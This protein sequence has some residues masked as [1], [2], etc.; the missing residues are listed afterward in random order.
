M[1]GIFG[2]IHWR[3]MAQ[4]KLVRHM[5]QRVPHRGPDGYS[6]HAEPVCVIGSG[7]LAII[8]LA[9]QPGVVYNEDG[10]VCIVFNGEIYNYRALRDELERAG[11]EFITRTDTEVI[12]HGYEEWGERVLDRL[13]GMF[14]F[15]IWDARA[16]ALFLAR[17]RLGEKP[18]Y[19]IRR[20]NGEFLFASETK[21][22]FEHP[23]IR[24]AVNM[25]ALPAYLTL[26]YVPPPMT[27]FA[28]I[29]KLAPGEYARLTPQGLT[30]ARY[31]TPQMNTETSISYEEAVRDVRKAVIDAVETRL[32]SDVPVGAFLS[33][34]VDST[35]VVAIMQRAMGQRLHTF[36]VGFD[37]PLGSVGDVKFNVDDQYAKKASDHIGTIHHRI[38]IQDAFV[39][40]LLPHLIYQMDEP[41]AQHSIIQTSYVAALARH[42][43]IPVLLSGDAGDELF[44]GYNHYQN[45]QML[46]RFLVLPALLREKVL[47]P[48]MER[49]SRWRELARK[50]KQGEPAARYLESMRVFS[51]AEAQS[52][53]I[54]PSLSASA[55]N[56]VRQ[57]LVPFLSAPQTPNFED[58]IAY[59]SL[60]LWIP[61]DSNMRVD[62][63]SM[64][65]SIESR[66]PLED[67]HLVD[68][69]MRLPSRYKLRG[70]NFKAVFKD[71]MKDFV[72][73]SI[74]DRPKWGFIPPTSD[75]LRT[76]F[77]PL[78]ETYL[79]PEYVAAA[80]MVNPEL[81]T[82][83][84][85][86][87][88]SKTGYHLKPLWSLL[89]LHIWH[90]L[91]IDGSLSI[92]H[93]VTAA[94][95]VSQARIVDAS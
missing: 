86:E 92:P 54:D 76:V 56:A 44:L 6:V 22:L 75:W 88:M 24:P 3:G 30:V 26:G 80:G 74:L 2:H 49:V 4:E 10:R 40:D 7:R 95:I 90:A 63:M 71:A 60:R 69:A 32:V 39:G 70:G 12:V 91:Y 84:V 5:V 36:T 83:W 15:A 1:S 29:S 94:D 78:V 18:L 67:H 19:Y 52:L 42:T 27:M 50:A 89:T 8:D 46:G 93:P 72:P 61:E 34:G 16:S 85:N 68:L 9:A 66:A 14:A 79:S 57:M 25:D 77:L 65:M 64:L 23:D 33:G 37:F 35:A 17:D 43:G 21:A 20:E 53:L 59:A 87:H 51:Q 41:I 13:R 48:L 38:V 28:G 58:R 45:D 11:H 62:K 31:W 55:R 81:V 47:V 82:R 73:Q